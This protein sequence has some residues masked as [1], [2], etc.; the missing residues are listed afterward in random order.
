VQQIL[1]LLAPELLRRLALAT[2]LQRTRLAVQLAGQLFSNLQPQSSYCLTR[3]K[4][5]ARRT[6]ERLYLP[7]LPTPTE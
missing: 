6:I 4:K 2:L 1:L 7:K 3:E 5:V